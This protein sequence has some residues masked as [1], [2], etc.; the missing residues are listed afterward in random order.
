MVTNRGAALTWRD[1]KKR[2]NDG[3]FAKRSC[4]RRKRKNQKRSKTAYGRKGNVS[5]SQKLAS[6]RKGNPV[7]EKA[8]W[9]K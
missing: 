9:G 7:K 1:E 2:P 4:K 8:R 3:G 6:E 5:S